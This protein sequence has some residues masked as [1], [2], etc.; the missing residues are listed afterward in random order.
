MICGHQELKAAERLETSGKIKM[1]EENMILWRKI[2]WWQFDHRFD[3]TLV[4][5]Q[6]KIYLEAKSSTCSILVSF[7]SKFGIISCGFLHI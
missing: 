1:P 6:M 7:R 4:F 3:H 2:F 5:V